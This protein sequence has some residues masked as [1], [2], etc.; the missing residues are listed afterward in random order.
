MIERHGEGIAAYC[1]PENKV[2]LGR[3]T[4][5]QDPCHPAARVRPTRRGTLELLLLGGGEARDAKER[6]NEGHRSHAN[7]PGNEGATTRFSLGHRV[8]SNAGVLTGDGGPCYGPGMRIA[9]LRFLVSLIGVQPALAQISPEEQTL[10]DAL[11]PTTVVSLTRRLSEDVVREPSGAGYGTAVAGSPE[12][13]A[14][15]DFIEKEMRARGFDVVRERFPVRSYDYGEV[16]L[17]VRGGRNG[18]QRDDPFGG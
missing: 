8:E 10:L 2:A 18:G 12:E 6:E 5:Q 16:K 3:G 11:D 4:E 1:Q 9:L 14:L 15:A 13:K 7:L 17:L